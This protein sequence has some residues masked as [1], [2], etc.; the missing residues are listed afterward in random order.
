M[1]QVHGKKTRL[2]AD[3][4]EFE[5]AQNPDGN[6]AP[7]GIDS[8]PFDVQALSAATALVA[9]AGANDLLIVDHRG[10]VD[11]IAA[12]PQELVSTANLKSLL[13]CPDVPQE[14]AF[15]AFACDLPEMIPAQPVSTSIAIGPDGAYYMAEL[16]ASPHLPMRRGYGAL[17]PARDTPRAKTIPRPTIPVRSSRPAS[18]RSSTCGSV[19]T[20]PCT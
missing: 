18:P 15:L 3:L 20:A 11:W 16:Q 10:N 1:Y 14:L 7:G 8:N 17:S 6:T 4:L 9:D 2:V 5:K 19:P 12:L 13:T